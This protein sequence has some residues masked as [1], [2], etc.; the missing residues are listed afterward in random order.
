MT[1][2]PRDQVKTNPKETD[3]HPGQDDYKIY[4]PSGRIHHALAE[5][6]LLP[7]RNRK[8]PPPFT[9]NAEVVLDRRYLAKDPETGA[10]TETPDEMLR[11]VARN[12]AQAEANYPGGK[13]RQKKVEQEFFDFM[14]RLDFLPNSPTL[15][16]AGRELQQLSACFV[17]PVEDNLPAIFE[18]V[19]QT[20]LIH[21][22]GG[23]T[24]FSFSRLR[25]E[26]DRVSGTGGV[27][28][29]PVSFIGAFDSA[30]EVVKQGGTRRGANMGILNHDHPDVMK[31]IRAKADGDY[32]NNFNISI[33]VTNRFMEQAK[34]KQD[35]NLVNP[36][37]GAITGQLNAAKVLDTMTELAWATGDPGM[38]FLDRM[39]ESNPNP[40]LGRVESTNPCGEQ[41]LLPFESCN[42]GSINLTNFVDAFAPSV[43]QSPKTRINWT[44]LSNCV[45]TS[46]RLLDDVIDMNQYPI[47]E[48]DEM[49]RK[50]R[51]IG[52][53][54]MGFADLLMM[55]G[56]PY[57]SADALQLAEDLMQFIQAETARHSGELTEERGCYPAWEG[58]VYAKEDPPRP[59]RNSA[60]VTIAPTGTIS[61]IAGVSSGIEPLFALSYVR[62]VMDRT[63]LVEVNPIFEAVAKAEGFYSPELMEELAEQ[64]SLQNLENV[65]DWAKRVFRTAQDISPE[66][67]VR[68]QAAFQKFTDNSVS[69]TINLP[70]DATVDDVK[71]AYLLAYETGCKGI[72][73]YRD[74]SKAEQVLSTGSGGRS[75]TNN[76]GDGSTPDEQQDSATLDAMASRNGSEEAEMPVPTGNS[77]QAEGEQQAP[78]TQPR[79]VKARPR[80]IQGITEKIRTGHG[81]L[82]VTVNFESDQP[83]E[84]FSAQ[85]KAGGCDSAQ[86]EAISR[87]ASLA[88]RSGISAE[89]V[90]SQ[91]EGITCCPMYDNGSLVRSAPD[92]IAQILQR[93]AQAVESGGFTPTAHLNNP[94]TD[95]VQLSLADGAKPAPL[96]GPPEGSLP[97]GRKCPDCNGPTYHTEGCRMCYA[98]GWSKCE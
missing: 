54:V 81:S 67:H 20:A 70:S 85:G 28:S 35:Y 21:K 23:G 30:T 19:K 90:V 98:C 93:H 80:Q 96:N 82:Y 38:V 55:L 16:N 11:R 4:N 59:M 63:K 94:G 25:P 24:G 75:I 15:M 3:T 5:A 97:A 76:A 72:T 41:I 32:L 57:D 62:N 34:K 86:L 89:K 73:V 95:S 43:E 65:P 69:K 10:V 92:G 78:K 44:E 53:G 42:L 22:S 1:L 48:I 50:T 71:K 77:P 84:I 60:P 8:E 12:L 29:G 36:R 39:N 87:L 56:I 26:G 17:L 79:L 9:K 58:G 64:G 47:P 7:D 66:W 68:M 6:E 49:S 14:R 27:A 31:F 18:R 83:F 61:I 13:K 40:S 52:V 74:Q 45:K 88:L 2:N 33:A 51:R 46:V 37:T 91:L